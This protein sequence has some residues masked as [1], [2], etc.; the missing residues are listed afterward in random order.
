M[1]QL[2]PC[3][4]QLS[5]AQLSMLS[6]AL[7]FFLVVSSPFWAPSSALKS[8]EE[9]DFGAV[10]THTWSNNDS[11][12]DTI[13]YADGSLARL[14]LMT[15]GNDSLSLPSFGCGFIRPGNQTTYF[16]FAVLILGGLNASV[17]D[18]QVW[19]AN[20]DQPI[21]ENGTLE[22][23]SKAG[24][25]L[26]GSNSNSGT[27]WSTGGPVEPLAG[28]AL[29]EDGNLQLYTGN[30]TVL[31]ESFNEPPSDTLLP[32]QE[33]RK[34]SKLVASVSATNW[35]SGQY[36]VEM[37]VDGLSAFVQADVPLKYF[38][39]PGGEP[40]A[41]CTGDRPQTYAVHSGQILDIC[42]GGANMGYPL[43]LESAAETAAGSY[44]YL[45]LGIDG[46]LTTYRW[47]KNKSVEQVYDFV[48]QLIDECQYPYECGGYGVCGRGGECS[49]PKA[50]DGRDYFKQIR[51]R[52]TGCSENVTLSCDSP[53]ERQ[54]LEN[55]GNLSL[56]NFID[57]EAADRD[58]RNLDKCKDACLNDCT[59]RAAFFRYG[60]TSAGY[61]YLLNRTLSFRAI[62]I[63][64]I[65]AY[66]SSAF[67]KIQLPYSVSSPN[68]SPP[69]NS[70]KE[71][72]LAA[73]VSGSVAMGIVLFLIAI[74]ILILKKKKKKK[75]M[76]MMMM[77]EDRD[78]QEEHIEQVLTMPRRFSYEELSI[79]TGNFEDR[80]GG[81]GFGTV[82]KGQLK[83]GTII[84]VKR[85]DNRGQGTREFLAE[86]ETIGNVNHVNLVRLIGFCAD[87]SYRLLIYEYMSNG[88][89]D[90]WIFNSQRNKDINWETRKKI[91]LDIARGLA[92]LHE[93]CR[94]RIA[95][96]DI[97]PQNILLDDDFNAKVSDF[98]LSKLMAKDQSQVQTTMRGTPG[99]LAPE[100]QQLR[101]TLKVDVYS[102]GI[103][104]LEIICG[105][106]NL[107]RSQPEASMH[108]LRLLQEKAQTNHLIDI[109]QNSSMETQLYEDEVLK[110]IKLAAW[111]LQ[112]DHTRR[113][114]MSVVVKVLEGAM[115]IE[116]SISYRFCNAMAR[117]PTINV[118]AADS[119]PPQ[120]SALSGPR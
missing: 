75:M 39:L 88:S 115:E 37:A 111:C 6:S 77:E 118:A 43:S 79:A 106:R 2:H 94:Q 10:E 100:W 5:S 49:C 63:P 108:L 97:K 3:W 30:H 98:G 64:D 65:D 71:N 44:H 29:G 92:Y 16:F 1:R 26:R 8:S 78:E 42:V 104:V 80:I 90:N 23:T 40:C 95:H 81:G 19:L 83:D 55:F 47:Q 116:P 113:P 4:E 109:V 48:A 32:G 56:F 46:H 66:N 21:R 74:G 120:A 93:Q 25:V 59:C 45:R 31:W 24:L 107:D 86:V 57:S 76:M 68:P 54:R 60:N 52:S 7:C 34:D 61:C 35:S 112:D 13:S 9:P 91:I 51:G 119:E 103:V 15:E 85:L 62:P 82:F 73:V 117:S 84:A 27:A 102:F 20:R 101:I 18:Q 12:T 58:F 50:A 70:K 99:Y 33:L 14:I 105:R 41:G 11:I 69:H 38:H 36:Y 67:I 96:L 89:L 72:Y 28:I 53:L 110:M 17:A 87:R 22:F 114:Q